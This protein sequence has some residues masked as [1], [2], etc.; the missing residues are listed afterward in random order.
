MNS[1]LSSYLFFMDPESG[2]EENQDPGSNINISQLQ[3]WKAGN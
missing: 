2:K 1:S 3:N